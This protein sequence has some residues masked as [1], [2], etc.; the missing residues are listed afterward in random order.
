MKKIVVALSLI[1]AGVFM[2]IG[3][4]KGDNDYNI[5]SDPPG[6]VPIW[7]F[8]FKC[9][10]M[11]FKYVLS[12]FLLCFIDGLVVKAQSTQVLGM[13][14]GKHWTMADYGF[15]VNHN[16]RLDKSES[17]I[18]SCEKDDVYEFFSD[19]S[20]LVRANSFSCCENL[21]EQH[22]R[23][24]LTVDGKLRLFSE[25]INLVS[26]IPD[27]MITSQRLTYTKGESMIL[28]TVYKTKY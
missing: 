13:L 10:R 2:L 7:S 22:F 6:G 19:G 16:G 12:L 15:D 26:L 27:E 24:Q 9:Y 5:V 18:E 14:T 1:L 3:C 23:W 28:I 21:D 25:T 11:L 4:D 17:R 20:G 8:T